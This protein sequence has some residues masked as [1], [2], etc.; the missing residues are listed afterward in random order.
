M[1]SENPQKQTRRRRAV[2]WLKDI[3]IVLLACSAVYLTV[4]SQF[5]TGLSQ[6][7]WLAQLFGPEDSGEADRILRVD[8]AEAVQPARLSV[9]LEGEPVKRYGA[10]YDAAQTQQD[11]NAF[12]DFFQ[13]ALATAQPPKAVSDLQWRKALQ[14]P[15]IYLDLLG[16][17]PMSA[18][19]QWMGEGEGN[20][21]LSGQVRCLALVRS[22]D[23]AAADLYYKNEEDGLYY[24]CATSVAYEGYFARAL[25]QYADNGVRFAYE[26]EEEYYRALDGEV[27]VGQE[28]VRPKGCQRTAPLN[29]ADSSSRA[30]LE[31]ALSFRGTDYQV[32]GEWVVRE[33][34]TLRLSQDGTVTFEA[35]EN[36]KT[37]RYPIES[38]EGVPSLT[39]SIETAR[40]LAAR[41]VD[42]WCGSVE[43][44]GRLYL[45][46]VLP[47][48]EETGWEILFQYSID[49][50]PVRLQKGY[51]AR[52]V[53]KEGQIAAYELV[54]RC[55][56][57][58]GETT[59]VLRELQAAAALRALNPN[60]RMELSLC[61]EEEGNEVKAGWVAG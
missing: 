47:L 52:F 10:Q 38:P 26:L 40:R 50:I 36:G 46:Q 1:T 29:M 24:A 42:V 21:N 7:G 30:A 43:S 28:A 17:V 18:L 55:Y 60:G 13:E 8:V 25:A 20:P 3:L 22:G 58:T 14:R 56:E 51:A 23:G 37:A 5:Y 33:E 49:G 4:R 39:Q 6:S 9:C 48:E 11:F 59:L 57:E 15:G 35:E 19:C 44:A 31:K 12:R 41:G 27:M 34:D 16:K 32:P 61:Y 53:V 2:E 54:L 45:D